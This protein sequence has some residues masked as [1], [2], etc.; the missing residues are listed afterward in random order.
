MRQCKLLDILSRNEFQIHCVAAKQTVMNLDL[1]TIQ[2][3]KYTN[4]F[5]SAKPYIT[6]PAFLL[7]LYFKLLAKILP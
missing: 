5:E 1:M 3:R 7:H 6:L 4:T 2:R